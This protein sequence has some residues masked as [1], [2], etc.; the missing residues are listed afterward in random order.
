MS[1]DEFKLII[2]F[3]GDKDNG[4]F[5]GYKIFD[6]IYDFNNNEIIFLNDSYKK[7]KYI[8]F[9]LILK[10]E[11]L[12]YPQS[13]FKFF[14]YKGI[15]KVYCFIKDNMTNL[16]FDFCFFDKNVK[17]CF[18][19]LELK[20]INYLEN[21]SRARIVLINPPANLFIN[22]EV[23][24]LPLYMPSKL[25]EYTSFQISSLGSLLEKKKFYKRYFK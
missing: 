4:S 2:N 9:Q 7:K 5:K 16:L 19:S 8:E 15:N 13:L 11:K 6:K 21:D 3:I 1:N 14:I 18:E 24:L 17:F 25:S 23:A 20:E 12:N 22:D 10:N